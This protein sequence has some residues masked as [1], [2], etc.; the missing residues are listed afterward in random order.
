MGQ[1]QFHN[2]NSGAASDRENICVYQLAHILVHHLPDSLHRTILRWLHFRVAGSEQHES[3]PWSCEAVVI[4]HLQL[5]TV[6]HHSR[7]VHVY[8]RGHVAPG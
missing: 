3:I 7:R 1:R 5:H 2:V 6:I 8:R 4:I